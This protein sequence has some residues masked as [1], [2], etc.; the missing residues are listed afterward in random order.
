MGNNYLERIFKNNFLIA[1]L[2]ALF[3]LV[4]VI[5]PA[6]SI[7]III[8]LAGAFLFCNGLFS[9]L[10]V[11]KL[12]QD[13]SFNTVI[14]IRGI[15]AIVFGLLAICLPLVLAKTVIKIILYV[16]ASFLLVHAV[17]DIYVAYKLH[18][19]EKPYSKFS[20]EAIGSLICPI[21]LFLLPADFGL[22][23][24]RIIG[25]ILLIAGS[26]FAWYE[27]KHR[28]LTGEA[29]ML[30]SNDEVPAGDSADDASEEKQE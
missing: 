27:W 10:S 22:I 30:P 29:E 11:R 1:V 19:E 18:K 17:S 3:G 23:I 16:V 5:S 8:M 28:P 20:G 12:I 4:L 24:L 6:D 2:A 9:L 13:P 21:I 25:I 15:L 7:R 26:A 14:L